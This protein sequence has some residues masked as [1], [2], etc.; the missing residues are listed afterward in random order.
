M[1]NGP[2]F[3]SQKFRSFSKTWDIL[4]KTISSHYHQSNDLAE[5]PS[6]DT[7]NQKNVTSKMITTMPYQSAT[8]LLIQFTHPFTHP[9]LMSDNQYEKPTLKDVCRTKSG[10]TVKKSKR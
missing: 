1:D 7:N 2:E 3:S 6:P 4:R 9:N 5:T 8:Y 10:R